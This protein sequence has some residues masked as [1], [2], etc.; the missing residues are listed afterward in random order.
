MCLAGVESCGGHFS[1][2][3]SKLQFS[4]SWLYLRIFCAQ[5]VNDLRSGVLRHHYIIEFLYIYFGFFIESSLCQKKP[6][7]FVVV[8]PTVAISK[9]GRPPKNEKN[10]TILLREST[11]N[12]WN[13]K[14]IGLGVQRIMKHQ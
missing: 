1:S 7:D 11:L 13:Q 2:V 5:Y 10:K 14:T 3:I 4:E 6:P 12:L 9:R 8:G